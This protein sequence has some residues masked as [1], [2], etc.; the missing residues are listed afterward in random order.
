[1]PNSSARRYLMVARSRFLALEGR[2][3]TDWFLIVNSTLVLCEKAAKNRGS[4]FRE[5]PIVSM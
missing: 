3:D 5:D 4:A 2:M 1:M